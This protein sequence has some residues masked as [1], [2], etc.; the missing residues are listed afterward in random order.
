MIIHDYTNDSTLE[1]TDM[2]DVEHTANILK[3]QQLWYVMDQSLMKVRQLQHRNSEQLHRLLI[4][5]TFRKASWELAC[6]R[7]LEDGDDYMQ[8]IFTM[9]KL[10]E[11]CLS[12]TGLLGRLKITLEPGDDVNSPPLL[13]MF[14]SK[15][16]NDDG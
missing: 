5:E 8:R 13:R 10:I 11:Q 1:D 12:R 6:Q 15:Q 16:R 9:A 4:K 7:A 14:P 2:L 3:E